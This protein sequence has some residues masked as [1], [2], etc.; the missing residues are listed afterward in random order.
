VDINGVTHYNSQIDY[1]L[2]G[3]GDA[4]QGTSKMTLQVPIDPVKPGE[5]T[6]VTSC[7]HNGTGQDMVTV[8]PDCYN[9][10]YRVTDDQGLIV[11]PRDILRAAYIIGVPGDLCT[12]PQDYDFCVIC[13]LYELYDPEFLKAGDGGAAKT[14]DVQ[15]TYLNNFQDRTGVY[16]L[17]RGRISSTDKKSVTVQGDP[18]VKDQA[19]VFFDPDVW[20][21]QWA[22]INGPPIEAII[23]EIEG[24]PNVSDVDV[25][26]ILLNGTVKIIN[27]SAKYYDTNGDGTYDVLTVQF[28]RPLA[29]QSLESVVPGSTVYPAVQG[30][31]NN[32]PNEIFYGQGS[33]HIVENTGT[34]VIQADL[35]ILGFGSR[36]F[37]TKK[38]IAGMEVRV[39]E[40]SHGSCAAQ[41]GLFCWYNYPGIWADCEPVDTDTTN[42]NGQAIFSL[43]PGNYLVIG[44]YITGS[45]TVYI[46]ETAGQITTGSV[47]EKHLRIIQTASGKVFPC[48]SQII[49]GSELLMIQPE[50]VEWSETE[51][52][53][54]FVFE[55]VGDWTVTTSVQPPEGF[56]AD[57]KSLTAQVNSDMEAV[58]F[59][60]TDVG[61]KWKPTKVKHKIKH[62][63]KVHKMDHEIGIK[64]TPELA[65][66]KRVSIF[67]Q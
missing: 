55:S 4:C 54:P 16:D 65:K 21:A 47:V 3:M 11:I 15:S 7:F 44:K 37:I 2:N 61:S 53:Y 27:G 20:D 62:K 24:H 52:M 60:I 9:I 45:T 56:V 43:D 38:P 31:F 42:A 13:D 19:E 6:W 51:E 29:V 35:Y 49:S 39:F 25:S 10:I 40:N 66:K 18:L 30:K 12:I 46:G 63:G 23:S 33:V 32:L 17:F 50:Y 48:L 26:T 1:D 64:L 5:P 36:P 59:T 22:S 57:N 14:Y 41:H 28:D 34:L 8:C 58:Q 67:G